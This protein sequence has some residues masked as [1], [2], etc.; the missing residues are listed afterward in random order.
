MKKIAVRRTL[1]TALCAAAA[2]AAV[3][4]LPAAH[5]ATDA[6]AIAI[7]R[8]T[9]IDRSGK[10]QIGI[11]S[12]YH[13]MFNGRKMAD[14]T[15]F[16]PNGFNAA[17]KSLPLGTVVRVTNLENRRSAVVRIQDRGPYVGDRIIDLP[18]QVADDLGMTRQGLARVEVAPLAVPLADG[19]L[20]TGD[21]AR[22]VAAQALRVATR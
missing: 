19:T 2:A 15:P 12:F 1:R 10:R 13:P 14:G 17:S 22:D 4:T 9:P 21:G 7:Q 20:R 3:A 11:A 18:P 5:A 8:A 16:D 6:E